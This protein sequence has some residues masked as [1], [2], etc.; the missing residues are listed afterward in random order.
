MSNY[1]QCLVTETKLG[2]GGGLGSSAHGR[3]PGSERP[4][5]WCRKVRRRSMDPPSLWP[6]K[7]KIGSNKPRIRDIGW[8]ER[9]LKHHHGRIGLSQLQR[10]GCT[11]L[12]PSMVAEARHCK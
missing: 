4:W 6:K 3:G 11:H 10:C 2:E 8:G 7:I 1:L 12:C 9:K 5:M